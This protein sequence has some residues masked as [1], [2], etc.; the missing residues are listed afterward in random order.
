ML[1]NSYSMLQSTKYTRRLCE[2]TN[3]GERASGEVHGKMM[4]YDKFIDTMS[5]NQVS[6]EELAERAGLLVE[7]ML[8]LASELGKMTK[9][10]MKVCRDLEQQVHEYDEQW[11]SRAREMTEEIRGR[12]YNVT[13][14]V[15]G[16][17]EGY[18]GGG[19]SESQDSPFVQRP[20]EIGKEG[21]HVI[22]QRA[23]AIPLDVSFQGNKLY[24]RAL[25]TLFPG[26]LSNIPKQKPLIEDIR[27]SGADGGEYL[28][29]FMSKYFTG[30]K[31][32]SGL[33]P[34][35]LV[36]VLEIPQDEGNI[37]LEGPALDMWGSWG[38]DPRRRHFVFARLDEITLEPIDSPAGDGTEFR[39]GS[40][41]G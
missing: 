11:R 39:D 25:A 30:G 19:G 36:V 15:Y 40:V 35:G 27:E 29:D 37:G 16:A 26:G 14:T 10:C 13:G 8:P 7:P 20:I 17:F 12:H 33:A 32:Q 6:Y 3:Q 24:L 1:I 41:E 23:N 38:D 2:M 21:L 28:A 31:I 34:F 18:S 4:P 22:G 5:K 9:N